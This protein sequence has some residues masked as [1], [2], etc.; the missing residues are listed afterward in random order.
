MRLDSTQVDIFC[1]TCG[2]D[3]FME[4]TSRIFI[5]NCIHED[6]K[7]KAIPDWI[8]KTDALDLVYLAETSKNIFSL[9]SR[10]RSIMRWDSDQNAVIGFKLI[11]G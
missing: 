9:D 1:N 4:E 3:I 5:C 10:A 2:V 7:Y 11:E 8:A 6:G